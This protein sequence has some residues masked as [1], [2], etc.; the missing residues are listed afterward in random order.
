MTEN[1]A[2]TRLDAPALG[3]ASVTPSATAHAQGTAGAITIMTSL[4]LALARNLWSTSTPPMTRNA[5]TARMA[6]TTRMAKMAAAASQAE[7]VETAM[8]TSADF[9]FSV[10]KTPCLRLFFCFPI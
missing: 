6:R 4:P 7:T 1:P 2:R 3:T 10:S 8:L 5:R 9:G